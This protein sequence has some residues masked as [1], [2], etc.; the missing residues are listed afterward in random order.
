MEPLSAV[1]VGIAHGIF[2]F[3]KAFQ[4]RNVVL[5]HYWWAAPTSYVMAAIDVFVISMVA[6]HAINSSSLAALIPLVMSIG[7]FDMIG[8]ITAMWIHNKYITKHPEDTNNG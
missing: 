7:T 1:A 6:V 5:L 3:F 2:V 8:A 4:Q